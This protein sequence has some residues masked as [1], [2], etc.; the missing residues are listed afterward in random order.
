M[1]T[2]ENP[3]IDMKINAM[4]ILYG[5]SEFDTCERA[6]HMVLDHDSENSDAQYVLGSI[7][8]RKGKLE[9]AYEVLKTVI[10]L[11]GPRADMCKLHAYVCLRLVPPKLSN[12]RLDFDFLVED[13]P[14][15]MNV[16]F[17]RACVEANMQD[18]EPCIADLTYVLSYE[19]TNS[20]VLLMRARA[21]ACARRWGD[22]EG[23]YQAILSE[24]PDNWWAHA[25]M[26][27]VVQV[28][29]ELPMVDHRVIAMIDGDS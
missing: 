16:L 26:A 1:N 20:G 8:A 18:W 6:C 5:M 4:K 28:Y 2:T 14:H 23:D 15:D 24:D 21:Y 7:Y 13:A 29:E 3:P 19:P 12:A 10:N 25:G 27:D 22:A 11:N 9:E 17:Q